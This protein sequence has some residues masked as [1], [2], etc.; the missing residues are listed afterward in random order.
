MTILGL[1]TQSSARP[2]GARSLMMPSYHLAGPP[3]AAWSIASGTARAACDTGGG[4]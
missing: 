3:G 2:R 1:G 4:R